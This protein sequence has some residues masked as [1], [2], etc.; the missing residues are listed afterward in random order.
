ML[1][2]V[3]LARELIRTP[4]PVLTGNEVAVA[5]VVDGALDRAGLPAARRVN[6]ADDRP[7]LVSTIDFGPGGRHLVLAGHIDTKPVADA[8]WSV[9]PYGADIIDGRLY[10][11]GSADMKAAVAAMIVAAEQLAASADGLRGRLSLVFTADEEDGAEFGAKH[12]ASRMGLDADA[13]IIGEPGGI[14]ADYDSLH[15]VS[16]GLARFIATARGRQG[17]SSLSALLGR[18]NAGLDLARAIAAIGDAAL[19]DPADGDGLRDWSSTV[20]PGLTY[21]GGYGYGVLPESMSARVEVRTLPGQSPDRILDELRGVLAAAARADGGELGIEFDNPPA[22]AIAATQVRA[23]SPIVECIQQTAESVLGRRLPL[24]VFPGT[25]DTTWFSEAY[26]ELPCLPALGPG[27]LQHAHGADE[28]V[29][30]EA[31]RAT[32]GLYGGIARAFMTQ[33][34]GE[35]S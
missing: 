5:E 32:P 33:R 30:V 26:P 11:L 7:N 2:T 34:E 25:T 18:R 8:R 15:L 23:Q 27:L 16:R 12:A 10:G 31:V 35:G 9:D 22:H 13:L 14:H 21:S 6:R 3:E 29:D 1:D 4:S 17:H 24:S 19:T 28:Y 20:N